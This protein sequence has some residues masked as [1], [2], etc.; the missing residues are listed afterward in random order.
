M[1]YTDRQLVI[2]GASGHASVVADIIRLQKEYTIIGY[3][4]SM[5]LL[6]K[7][8]RF[9]G[10]TILGGEAELLALYSEGVEYMIIG[11]GECKSRLQAADRALGIGYKLAT[12]IHPRA[13]IAEDVVIGAGTVV[14]A[15]AVVN[16]GTEI[17]GN[18]II[19]TLSSVDHGCRIEEGAHICPGARLSGDVIV[20]R[21]AWIG[22]GASIIN[23]VSIGAESVVGVGSVVINDIP[24]GVVAYG[25]PASV[26]RMI[27]K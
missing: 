23:G 21:S 16:P 4:D 5:N 25:N 20:G 26:R 7:G 13:V 15:N 22:T 10:K 17:G 11:F 27:Q 14:A 6:R 8:E 19:N 9:L 3:L 2:W 18:V 1:K 24:P 12:A